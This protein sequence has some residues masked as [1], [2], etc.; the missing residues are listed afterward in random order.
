M[1]L[2]LMRRGKGGDATVTV[3]HSRS[4]DLAEITR[5][6]NIVIA[7]IGRAHFLGANILATMRS[8]STSGI[9]RMEDPRQPR[10]YRIVGDVDYDGGGRAMRRDHAGARRSGPDDD[11][12]ALANTVDRL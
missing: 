8:S 5:P 6:P 7:A 11:R 3:A 2:L 9:N 1:A 12:D 4:R 10:G